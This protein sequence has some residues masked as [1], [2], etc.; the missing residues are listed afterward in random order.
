M[1]AVPLKSALKKP[2]STNVADVVKINV[3]PE[4]K[5]SDVAK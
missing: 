5:S 2:K 1:N 3:I 4:E